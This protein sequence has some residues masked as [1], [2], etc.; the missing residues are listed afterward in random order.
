MKESWKLPESEIAMHLLKPTYLNKVTQSSYYVRCGSGTKA[1]FGGQV[2]K[3]ANGKE[4][5]HSLHL[6]DFG[7]HSN[8]ALGV[9][10]DSEPIP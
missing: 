10:H 5:E 4:N 9:K 8:Y 3:L 2:L 6:L 7:R 1:Q